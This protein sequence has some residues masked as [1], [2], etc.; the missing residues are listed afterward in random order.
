MVSFSPLAAVERGP[1]CWQCVQPKMRPLLF[2]VAY[3]TWARYY[4]SLFISSFRIQALSASIAHASN[5]WRWHLFDVICYYFIGCERDER[6]CIRIYT[7]THDLQ[8]VRIRVEFLFCV[9]F[10]FAT[11]ARYRHAVIVD[12]VMFFIQRRPFKWAQ[13]V[14]QSHLSGLWHVKIMCIDKYATH[15]HMWQ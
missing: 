5:V 12:V 9:F 6:V 4:A 7:R 11:M 10:S 15:I 14:S 8:K 13:V 1:D 3:R 2:F